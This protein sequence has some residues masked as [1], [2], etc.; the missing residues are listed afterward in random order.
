MLLI[1]HIKTLGGINRQ[2]AKPLAGDDLATI[3]T[4]EN[5]WLVCKDG[6]IYDFGSMDALPETNYIKECDEHIN[7]SERMVLPCFVDSHTHIVFAA[8]RESEFVDR[9]K[10]LT[11]EEIA[12]NGGGILNSARK[13]QAMGEDELYESAWQRLHQCISWGTGAIEI[14]SGYGLTVADELKMLR[15]IKRLKASSSI[16]IKAT[17]LGAHAVPTIYKNDREGYIKLI[18]EEML[19]HVQAE[20]LADYI[21]V[22]CDRGFF[23]VE[24]TDRILSAG[25]KYKLKAKIHANELGITG[26]VQAGVNHQAIS[27]DHLEH[28]GP[29]E[30]EALLNSDTI[31]TLLPSTAFFLGIPYPDAR[32]MIQ[33]GLPVCLAS[34]FNPG[35]SPS[36]RMAF[37]ISLACLRMKMT[38]EEAFNAATINGAYALELQDLVGSIDKGKL[39]NIFITKPGVTLAQIPYYFGG[40]LIETNIINGQVV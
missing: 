32:S 30:I 27:V 38:P 31:P 33:A 35:S 24:E 6:S 26:G 21:D 7:A 2:L 10:G 29:E 8:S 4:I 39:A 34:D 17:F 9:I 40:D 5:A 12:A 15:V 14:K 18:I 20:G 3:H 16:P 1:S 23:T 19:P 37:V 25:K 28:T 36:G 13:L 11:Y 22:F